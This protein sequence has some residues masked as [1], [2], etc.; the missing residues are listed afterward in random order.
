[1]V[2]VSL[3]IVRKLQGKQENVGKLAHVQKLLPHEDPRLCA[4]AAY[5][6]QLKMLPHTSNKEAHFPR[7][8]RSNG[9]PSKPGNPATYATCKGVATWVSSHV[10]RPVTFKDCDAGFRT[11]RAFAT[12][13]L[14]GSTT[15]VANAVFV[16]KKGVANAV[17]KR[18]QPWLQGC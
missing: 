16:R 6:R 17:L 11:K 10:G 5:H 9:I 15:C 8:V 2:V 13:F 12:P 1:M 4:V 7:S 14:S 3:R 18:C